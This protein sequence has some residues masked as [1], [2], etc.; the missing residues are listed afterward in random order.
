MTAE[1]L[2]R[3]VF[4]PSIKMPLERVFCTKKKVVAQNDV[5][6]GW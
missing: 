5:H 4:K 6:R 3:A 1:S 2:V